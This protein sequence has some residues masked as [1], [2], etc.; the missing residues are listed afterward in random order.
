MM[1]RWSKE[2]SDMDK[3]S[4]KLVVRSAEG[5]AHAP[6]INDVATLAGVSVATVSRALANPESVRAPTRKRVLAAVETTGYVPNM[7]ARN[8]RMRRV[9]TVLAV[10]PDG[11]N[12]FF[13]VILQALSE[14]LDTRG[15]TL[16]V[17]DTQNDPHK[18]RRV[19]GLAA[20][21]QVDGM[22]LLNGKLVGPLVPVATLRRILPMVSLCETIAGSLLPHVETANR[23]AARTMTEYLLSLGHRRI[24]YLQGPADNI[25]EHERQQG[26]IEALASAGIA[27]DISLIIPGDF[28]IAAGEA[29]ARQRMAEGQLPDAVFACNDA[30]AMGLIRTFAAAGFNVPGD[31]SVAGFDDIEFAGAYNP[32]I[33]TMHQERQQIGRQAAGIMADLIEGKKPTVRQ[34]SLPAR[35]VI[36][37][38][39]SARRS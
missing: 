32:G 28:S 17:A 33:T 10:V 4:R 29:A 38:S 12:A 23:A 34:I 13:P 6:R 31:I 21:G 30:M 7:A 39:T 3:G 20:S 9:G 15:F 35:L 1:R 14:A 26:Y 37:G 19:A 8:L 27:P 25:L 16:V 18:E 2:S 24:A 36:R 11:A 22:F 5:S